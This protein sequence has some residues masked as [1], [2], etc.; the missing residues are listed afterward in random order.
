MGKLGEGRW[1]AEIFVGKEAR[2]QEVMSES[3]LGGDNGCF[4]HVYLIQLC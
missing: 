4:L 2:V 1:G 3:C